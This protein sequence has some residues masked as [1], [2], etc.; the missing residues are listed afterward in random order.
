MRILGLDPGLAAT[1]WGVI[2]AE[3]PNL[4]H[5]AHGRI[6]TRPADPMARRLVALFDGISAVVARH[7]P[8]R[9]AVEEAFVARNPRSALLLGQARGVA[10]LAAG[11]AG[12][13]VTE[14]AARFVK[15]A[16][17]GTGAADK[18][19]VAFMV[20]RL[21][22]CSGPVPADAADALAIAIAAAGLGT[23]ASA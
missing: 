11:R 19:Q 14:V 1:G 6:A 8:H 2:E 21:L 12:L 20:S 15:Q 7:A 10:L 16:L 22:P 13:A 23:R 5:L 9:V 4:V 18:A 17:T 3:G